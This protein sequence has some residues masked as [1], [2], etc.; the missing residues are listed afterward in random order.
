M[1]QIR[2][3]KCNY[4]VASQLCCQSHAF[5]EKSHDKSM[6]SHDNVFLQFKWKTIIYFSK[7]FNNEMSDS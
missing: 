3:Q 1:N 7:I 4:T 2:T 5:L 6:F